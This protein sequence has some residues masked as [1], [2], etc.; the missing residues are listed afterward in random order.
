MDRAILNGI[1]GIGFAQV[2]H[3]PGGQV[4]CTG[5]FEPE[6]PIDALSLVALIENGETTSFDGVMEDDERQWNLRFPVTI[7]K[8]EILP[9]TRRVEFISTSNPYLHA[10]GKTSGVAV[11]A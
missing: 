10:D 2:H 3:E 9:E 4:H 11:V 5:T 1:H 6:D 7:T 8:I